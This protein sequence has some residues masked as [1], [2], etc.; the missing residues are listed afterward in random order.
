MFNKRYRG[1][2]KVLDMEARQTAAV[3]S[4]ITTAL[5]QDCKAGDIDELL[6]GMVLLEF[7]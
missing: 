3:A 6:G 4:D 5:G 1:A 2:Q 7:C